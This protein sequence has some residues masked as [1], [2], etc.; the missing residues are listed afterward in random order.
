MS[1]CEFNLVRKRGDTRRVTFYIKS[2][3]EPVDISGWTN[4]KLGIDSRDAP[5]D[6]STSL[7]VLEGELLT[8]GLDGKVFFAVPADTPAGDY[9]YDAQAVDSNG[10]VWTFVEGRWRVKEDRTK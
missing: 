3:G 1:S 2:A 4:F 9:F 5:D 6:S 7:E 10:E 8:D